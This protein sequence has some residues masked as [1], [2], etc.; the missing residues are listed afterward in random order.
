MPKSKATQNIVILLREKKRAVKTP[1]NTQT[2][3]YLSNN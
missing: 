2:S 1:N 3:I